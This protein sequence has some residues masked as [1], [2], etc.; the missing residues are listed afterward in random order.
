MPRPVQAQG[1]ALLPQRITFGQPKDSAVGQSVRLLASTDADARENLVVSFRSDTPD[2]CTVS[3][4]TVTPTAPG[5]C[6]ITATQGGDDRYA[7]AESI[8]KSFSVARIPQTIDFRP[9]QD[10]AVGRPVTLI[11]T[12]SSGCR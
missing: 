7:A 1:P 5:F 11:A 4:D 12:A 10:V 3:G 6:I 8:R 9:P 2:L